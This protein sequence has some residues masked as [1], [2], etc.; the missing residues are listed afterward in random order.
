MT[1]VQ[2]LAPS[3]RAQPEGH[4]DELRA[5]A[6]DHDPAP[7]GNSPLEG[8][9]LCVGQAKSVGRGSRSASERTVADKSISQRAGGQ[10]RFF[11]IPYAGLW[12][13]TAVARIPYYG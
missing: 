5:A 1:G 8:V 11:R 6:S 9:V 4:D 2:H 7:V 12:L 3:D 13:G 10:D